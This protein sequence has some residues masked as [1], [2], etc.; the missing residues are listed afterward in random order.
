M[1]S[2]SQYSIQRGDDMSIYAYGNSEKCKMEINEDSYAVKKIGDYIV[3]IVADG[4]G[5]SKGMINVGGM[6]VSTMLDYLTHM[7]NPNTSI[8]DIFNQIE[9][10]LFT[11]SRCFLA[12][13]AIDE[14]YSNIYA[15]MTVGIIEEISLNAVFASIGNTEV[16]LI[17]NGEIT[18][19]NKLFSEAYDSYMKGEISEEELYFHPKRAILTS[20]LGVFN[21]AKVDVMK[22]QLLKEDILLLETDGI[23]CCMPPQRMIEI[24]ANNGDNINV[25]VDKILQTAKDEDCQDNCTLICS[26]IYNDNSISTTRGYTPREQYMPQKEQQYNQYDTP[27]VNREGKGRENAREEMYQSDDVYRP[28]TKKKKKSYM[29]NM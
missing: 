14:R 16:K 4:N 2:S 11:V 19:I 10:G 18:R 17:R 26:Y 22:M 9:A 1:P 12:M 3:L 13:N 6:A 27:M 24:L 15:S 23:Y 29:Y 8:I 21:E 25:A 20:A 7:I 5:G 28:T